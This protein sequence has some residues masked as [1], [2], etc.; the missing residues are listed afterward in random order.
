[1]P[2]ILIVEDETVLAN[3]MADALAGAGYA[4]DVVYAGEKVLARCREFQ[5]Q[6]VLLDVRLGAVSGID[7]LAT[8]KSEWPQMDAIVLTAYG[9]VEIAVE[10]MKRGAAEFLTKPIDL[11][12]LT[13]KV[14]SVWSASQARRRLEQFET[15]Q[16]ERLKQVQLLG[17]CPPIQEIRKLV[18]RLAERS[19]GAGAPPA[20]ILLTGETGTGKDLLAALLHARL[21]YRHGPFVSVNCAAVPSELFESELFGHKRGSFSGATA[22][23][24][25]LFETADGGTLLLDE[26]ADMPP[27]LQPKLLRAIETQNIRRIGETQDR[28]VRL[29]VIAATNRDLQKAVAERR[30]R[31]DLYFRLKVVT[32]ELPPLRERGDDIALL[33]DHFCAVLAAKYALP[34]LR[35]APGARDALAR[36]SWPGNVRELLNA[37]ERA[38]LVG[39]GPEITLADLRITADTHRPASSGPAQALLADLTAGQIIDLEKLEKAIIEQALQQTG[40]NA[41]AAARLLSIGREAM[42]YRMGKF[43]LSLDRDA[44]PPAEAGA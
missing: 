36:Y 11:D 30:F 44:D 4:T 21:P 9:S 37:L 22:D 18:E 1:M 13:T 2:R 28:E 16:Q 7:L 12:V 25:G 32:I 20:S 42:R 29:C 41:S 23:K 34:A 33:A 5:P 3:A 31:E 40:G 14:G 24:V 10:A 38:A 39:S 8:L 19:T 6:I 26:I 35:L 43:G 17:Q 27:A 15:A